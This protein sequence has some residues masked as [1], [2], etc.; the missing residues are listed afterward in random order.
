MMDDGSTRV[1]TLPKM[2]ETTFAFFT[3]LLEQYKKALV[4]PDEPTP[5]EPPAQSLPATQAADPRK[6]NT[7]HKGG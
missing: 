2:S 1:I 7:R 3:G 6:R 5:P 4:V